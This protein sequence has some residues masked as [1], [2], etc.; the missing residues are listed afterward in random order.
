VRRKQ[1]N[2]TERLRTIR[3]KREQEILD[4]LATLIPQI[5][6][7]VASDCEIVLHDNRT[8][9]PQIMAI[10]NGHVTQRSVGDLMTRVS[11]AG[12]EIRDLSEPL[13]NYLSAAPDGR[14]MKVSV[15]PIVIDGETVA[16]IAVNII[17]DELIMAQKMLAQLTST[18]PHP[19]AIEETFLPTSGSLPQIVER[20]LEEVPRPAHLL[21]REERIELMRRM[22]HEGAFQFRG[23]VPEIARRLRMSRASVYNY[24]KEAA[25]D[26]D[27]GVDP[28]GGAA[29][30]GENGF[31]V[32]E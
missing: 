27:P 21:S 30:Q 4:I 14:Q 19:S 1:N 8:A 22:H 16:Y 28:D 6:R 25:P 24:L 17:L 15:L 32:P 13:Y 29:S 9:P 20:C 23:A 11:I 26:G 18:E 12:V 3:D 31:H 2:E 7:S 10:G 5:A